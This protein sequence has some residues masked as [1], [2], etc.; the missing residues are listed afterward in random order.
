MF[1]DKKMSWRG[2]LAAMVAA[3]VSV[4]FDWTK[5]QA[6][7]SSVEP[8]SDYPVVVIGVGVRGYIKT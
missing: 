4:P 6:L 1:K 7:A 8:K 5:I 2:V 3:M